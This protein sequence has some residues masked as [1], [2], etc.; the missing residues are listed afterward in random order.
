MEHTT[1]LTSELPDLDDALNRFEKL[2]EDLN[3]LLPNK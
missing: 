2:F 1:E 3:K